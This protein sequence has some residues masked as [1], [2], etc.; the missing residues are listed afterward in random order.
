LSQQQQKEFSSLLL[1]SIPLPFGP[2]PF[3]S[4]CCCAVLSFAGYV[5]EET[6]TDIPKT[7]RESLNKKKEKKKKQKI[8]N[9][10]GITN[11]STH[12]SLAHNR[13]ESVRDSSQK[14]LQFFRHSRIFPLPSLLSRLLFASPFSQPACLA[15]PVGHGTRVPALHVE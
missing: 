6:K 9:R 4:L 8:Q 13:A 12:I 3:L 14:L 7:T 11:Q 1:P 2:F 15:S 5:S 10:G